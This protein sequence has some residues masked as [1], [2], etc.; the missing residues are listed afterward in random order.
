VAPCGVSD[1][2]GALERRLNPLV[3]ADGIDTVGL[4]RECVSL[5][6]SQ[7]ESGDYKR[8]RAAGSGDH[9]ARLHG[10]GNDVTIAGG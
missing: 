9:G 6:N 4:Y 10:D 1:R 8:H 3:D 2:L 5:A 7:T